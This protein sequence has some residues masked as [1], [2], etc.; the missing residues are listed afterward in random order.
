M[1]KLLIKPQ[2]WFL[3]LGGFIS[4]SVIL[5]ACATPSNSA[6][7]TVFKARS[8]QFFNGEQGSLQNALAT[9]LKDPEANKQFVAAP[10]LKALTAWYENNQDKQVTQ[11]FKDTKKS[12]DEQYNQAV[13]KVVSASRNKNLFFQQDLLDSAGGG[14][15]NLKS[16]E[17]VWTA[18]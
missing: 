18:H 6:L 9:A 12:V 5:V 13:D 16:P 11:F 15:R 7:Q 3:T 4:S 8:N 2:F 1:K 10:L 17:V 14:V